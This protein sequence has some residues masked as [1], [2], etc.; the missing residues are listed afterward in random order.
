MDNYAGLTTSTTYWAAEPAERLAP[1][2]M[3][4]FD[5]WRKYFRESGHAGKALNGHKYFHGWDRLHQ[6]AAALAIGGDAREYLRVVINE[7]RNKVQWTLGMLSARV[8]T[9]Q[10][11]AANSNSGAK[12]ET[13]IAKQV[14]EHMHRMHQIRPLHARVRKVAFLMSEAFRLCLWDGARGDV[15]QVRLNDATGLPEPAAYEG[16]FLNWVLSPFDVARDP[17]C[18]EWAAVPWAICRV[19]DNKWDLAARYPEKAAQIL[20]LSATNSVLTGHAAEEDR[21]GAHLATPLS[22]DQV[23]VYHFFHKATP[24]LPQGRAFTCLSASVWLGEPTGNPYAGLPCIRMAPDNVEGTTLG[25]TNVFDA[26]GLSDSLNILHSTILTGHARWGL[27]AFG[28]PKDS[29]VALD[30][31]G[32]GSPVVEFSGP[33]VP[34]ALQTP[35]TDPA[36]EKTIQRLDAAQLR[37]F[38]LNETAVGQL[39]FAGMPSSLVAQLIEKAYQYQ[40]TFN[41]AAI[42]FESDA[43]THELDTLKAF[44]QEP[45]VYEV[46]SDSKQWMVREFSASDLSGVSRVAFEPTPAAANSLAGKQMRLETMA[47]LRQAGVDLSPAEINEFF[48]TGQ[49]PS[50][51]E[52]EQSL[53]IMIEEAKEGLRRARYLPATPALP[54]VLPA[55][56]QV[57][58]EALPLLAVGMRT[59]EYIPRLMELFNEQ[60]EPAVY[61]ATL[62]AVGE[63]VRVWQSTPPE[64]LALLGAPPLPAPPQQPG[65]APEGEMQAPAQ[66]EPPM[67][68][69]GNTPQEE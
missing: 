59:W 18:R 51:Y 20:S 16:D 28:L 56:P 29:G 34:G 44:A 35:Q 23:W 27:G 50:R 69:A 3:G 31:L 22:G 8:P 19:P 60:H 5:D 52:A 24:A 7:M 64:L 30:S 57:D 21:L 10:P 41:E 26:L 37:S 47:M 55:P 65:M 40:D 33:T 68:P 6:S 53:L 14:L 13:L 39:P 66:A 32:N 43:A 49:L 54:G 61:E 58:P 15:T 2:L 17:T 46:A 12:K 11:I 36:M 62:A 25:D 48:D 38:G 63:C 67:L 45:R 1:H 9:M 42:Q 4:K